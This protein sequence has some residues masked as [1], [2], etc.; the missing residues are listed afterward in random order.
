MTKNNMKRIRT[1]WRKAIEKWIVGDLETMVGIKPIKRKESGNLN[2]A[3]ALV[4][5][6]GIEL[7]GKLLLGEEKEGGKANFREFVCIYFPDNYKNS[8]YKDTDVLNYLY[9]QFR[10]GLAHNM[11]TKDLT[12]ISKGKGPHLEFRTDT[13]GKK[14]FII[15]SDV[16]FK[17]FKKAL[18]RYKKDLDDNKKGEK[19]FKL[20]ALFLKFIDNELLKENVDL[21]EKLVKKYSRTQTTT[22]L[23][24]GAPISRMHLESEDYKQTTTLSPNLIRDESKTNKKGQ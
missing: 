16:L 22:G 23:S 5:F 12:G 20:R 21:R 8:I 3:I 18:E 24:S 7:A 15:N 9:E 14:V 11:L 19:D 17:H 6:S 2:F 4:C 13:S 10:N 1:F